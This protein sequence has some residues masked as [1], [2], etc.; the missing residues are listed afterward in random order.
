[1]VDLHMGRWIAYASHS[2]FIYWIGSAVM[3]HRVNGNKDRE[4]KLLCLGDGVGEA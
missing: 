3:P 4:V 1:M 2:A